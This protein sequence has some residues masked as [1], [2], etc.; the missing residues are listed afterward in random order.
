MLKSLVASSSSAAQIAAAASPD[1][2]NEKGARGKRGWGGDTVRFQLQRQGG[3]I[4]HFSLLVVHGFK[5][6]RCVYLKRIE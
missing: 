1:T 5:I 6:A 3:N 4:L 2:R